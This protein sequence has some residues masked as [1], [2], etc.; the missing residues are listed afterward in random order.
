MSSKWCLLE[1][2]VMIGPM[3][4]TL[5]R[6]VECV[7]SSMQ[8]TVQ[9]LGSLALVSVVL[10]TL[11]VVYVSVSSF[12]ARQHICYSAYMLSPVRLSVCQMGGSYKN[13]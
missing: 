12:Y 9:L 3:R 2:M 7:Q 4:P 13:G 11:S 1:M 8:H 10:K 6:T 5:D